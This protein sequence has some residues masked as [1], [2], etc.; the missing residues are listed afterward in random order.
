MAPPNIEDLLEADCHAICRFGELIGYETRQHRYFQDIRGHWR[1]AKKL[2]PSRRSVRDSG[3]GISDWEL[4]IERSFPRYALT[5]VDEA[6][7]ESKL[8]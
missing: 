2:Y 1:R 8:D 7:A 5:P 6:E 4:G 3:R